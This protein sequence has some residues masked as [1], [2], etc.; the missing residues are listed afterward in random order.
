[1][2]TKFT[3]LNLFDMSYD[4]LHYFSL[5]RSRSQEP[6]PKLQYTSSGSG[7][8]LRLRLHNTVNPFV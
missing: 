4:L 2:S 3:F 5:T 6:G 8:K 7:Q 1:M